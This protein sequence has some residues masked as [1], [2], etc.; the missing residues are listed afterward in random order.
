MSDQALFELDD[1]QLLQFVLNRLP[2]IF[3]VRGRRE[4]HGWT[5]SIVANIRICI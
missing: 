1:G 5:T 2:V 4:T 3:G